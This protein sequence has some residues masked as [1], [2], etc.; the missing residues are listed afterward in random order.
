MYN[1]SYQK[2]GGKK[3]SLTLN[4][5]Y[6]IS[7][8]KGLME[9]TVNLAKTQ[10]YGQI[11]ETVQ[12]VSVQGKNIIINGKITGE[13][14]KQ[15]ELID[16]FSPLSE[17]RLWWNDKYWIDAVVSVSPTIAQKAEKKFSLRLFV[18][19]P[20]WRDTKGN[21]V[22]LGGIV[23]LFS[24]PVMYDR[25]IFGRKENTGFVNCY[26]NGNIETP[27]D[28]TV[29]A[30]S[31]VTNI[32]VENATTFKT[33]SFTGE[34]KAGQ[35]LKMFRKNNRLY[36]TL[37]DKNKFSLLDESSDFFALSPN[38]NLIVITTSGGNVSA[39][40]KYYNTYIGVTD[41]I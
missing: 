36:I 2:N 29:H 15:Q 31:D 14:F 9:H 4:N 17:G 12:N 3:V 28:L 37:D 34:I 1:I 6:I 38:D 7:T 39:K 41:G 24:F 23:P 5:G 21:T 8:V 27:F 18:P 40:I 25:H 26:N 11:G 32:T 13:A 35:T 20:F 10:G 33:L 19:Y 30:E 22:V 16:L